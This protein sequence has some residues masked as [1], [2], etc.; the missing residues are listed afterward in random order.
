MRRRPAC[1]TQNRLAFA[2]FQ[3]ADRRCPLR[4]ATH[5]AVSSVSATI[6]ND[7]ACGLGARNALCD[8]GADGCGRWQVTCGATPCVVPQ[9]TSTSARSARGV[10]P[11]RNVGRTGKFRRSVACIRGAGTRGR[12]CEL[13]SAAGSNNSGIDANVARLER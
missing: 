11:G 4:K 12:R 3:A 1:S 9:S 10:V 2:R 13:D 6:E 7:V 5:A 8:G